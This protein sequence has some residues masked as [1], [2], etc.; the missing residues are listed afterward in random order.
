MGSNKRVFKLRSKRCVQNGPP[1]LRAMAQKRTGNTTNRGKVGLCP[2]TIIG[3]SHQPNPK[4][5][6]VRPYTVWQ[7]HKAGKVAARSAT[8]KST[9]HRRRRHTCRIDPFACCRSKVAAAIMCLCHQT[10]KPTVYRSNSIDRYLP[11]KVIWRK[12]RVLRK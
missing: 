7:R 10:Q 4:P 1:F 12:L 2:L 8:T 5:K 11:N 3:G 9:C 6:S